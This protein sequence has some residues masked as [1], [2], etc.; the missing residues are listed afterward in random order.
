MTTI[1]VSKA[2]RDRLAH[3]ASAQGVATA[4]LIKRLLDRSEREA[5]FDAVRAAYAQEDPAYR[6]ETEQ[7]ES[8]A[9]EDFA[10]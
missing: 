9:D 7:W 3:E 2:L 4:E 5:R 6:A 8:L 10:S 1:K